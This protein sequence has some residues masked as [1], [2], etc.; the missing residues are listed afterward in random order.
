MNKKL[1]LILFIGIFIFSGC[2]MFKELPEDAVKKF[3]NKYNNNDNE[4]I[5]ELDNFLETEDI[6]EETLD[7]Y[8]T[9]YLRQYSN[10]DYK[11]K[12]SSINGNKAMVEVNITV[13]DYYKANIESLD[14]LN[15]NKEEFLTSNGDIDFDK[16]FKY[17]ID[18]LLN[19]T[20]TVMYT[21]ILELNK[22]NDE[23]EIEPLTAEQLEKIHGT[24]EY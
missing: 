16:Y 23:W 12:E 3:F 7:K 13:Y 9:I 4:V 5:T 24:Y 20:D 11:I 2:T 14:Y 21:I 19:E 1:I 17:K 8:R 15:N 6:D 10:I 22:V 18:K